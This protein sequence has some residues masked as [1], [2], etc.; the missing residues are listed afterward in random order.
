[1]ITCLTGQDGFAGWMPAN[2]VREWMSMTV[3]AVT[4][5]PG[6]QQSRRGPDASPA[7]QEVLLS[8]RSIPESQSRSTSAPS[9]RLLPRIDVL[10]RQRGQNTELHPIVIGVLTDGATKRR[11]KRIEKRKL[12]QKSS[13][14]S[15]NVVTV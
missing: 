7:G 13:F 1:M 5:Q 12:K 11:R 2:V 15:P 9:G 10:A 3:D 4:V 8:T 14:R 6:E